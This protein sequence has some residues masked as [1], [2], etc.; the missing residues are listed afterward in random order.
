M[1]INRRPVG[2]AR[3]DDH[4]QGEV[5]IDHLVRPGSGST[6]SMQS[7]YFA[8]GARTPWHSHPEG[9]IIHVVAGSGLIQVRDG[10]ATVAIGAGD[11]VVAP[12]GEWHWHGADPDSAMTMIAVQGADPAG[13]FVLWGDPVLDADYRG[14][15]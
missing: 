6:L 3:G 11:T 14:M 5:W 10:G 1:E 4:F 12:P 7:V 13:A 9:Q 8:P 15:T 2:T